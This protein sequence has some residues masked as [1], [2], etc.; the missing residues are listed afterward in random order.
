MIVEFIVG[1]YVPTWFMIK[2]KHNWTEGPRHFLYQLK[3]LKTQCKAVVDVV[4]PTV[5]RFAWYAFS[6]NILQ[7]MLCSQHEAERREGVQKI[8]EIRRIKGNQLGDKSV[9]S[10]KTPDINFHLTTL[11]N[12]ID[13]TDAHV[14]PCTC[15]LS[16]DKL[17][18]FIRQPM[19]VPCWPCH[20]QSIERRVKQV[21]EACDK[22]YTHE[23]RDGWIRN[24]EISRQ[25]MSK[26]E[27]KQ[28]LIKLVNFDT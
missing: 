2:V 8:L 9:R 18:S 6:E 3:Q 10:R 14:P 27:S 25:L 7:T 19:E 17:K 13:W 26:N 5:K 16:I 28:D 1:V 23:R 15:D 12:L 22:A 11:S 24:Q 4:M 21:T 20:A